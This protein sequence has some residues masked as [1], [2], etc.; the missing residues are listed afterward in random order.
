MQ[1]EK[2]QYDHTTEK[3]LDGVQY[4]RGISALLVVIS[5]CNGIIAKP[6]FYAAFV[7]PDLHPASVFAVAVFFAISGFII[8]V[9]S[10]DATAQAGWQPRMNAGEFARRRAIRILPF[11][12][13]CTLGYNLLSWAGT[14]TA[15]P[16][17]MLRTLAVWPVG[18]LKPN[19]VW[20]LRHELL[21][22]GLFA[23]TMMGARRKAWLLWLWV[24]ASGL[25]Y[26]L[27]YDLRPAMALAGG[28]WFEWLKVAMGGDH[29]ANL[30]FAAGMVLGL[31]YLRRRA[32]GGM[33][34]RLPPA[35]ML[36]LI[37]LGGWTV[38]TVIP[39]RTGVGPALAWT[40]LAAATLAAAVLARPAG[41]MAGRIGRVLGDA[42]FAIY[43]VHNPV[44]LALLALAKRTALP[45][46]TYPALVAFL[47]ASI[48]MTTL[49]GIAA[50]YWV[51]APLIRWCNRRLR[52]AR[53]TAPARQG[54]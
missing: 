24:G 30:Q 48:V 34:L 15:E 50:H 12:W 39:F 42:S 45:L 37:A 21:F 53:P 28:A 10:L 4:L 3:R 2:I 52:P 6:E 17:A 19:V 44:M 43:L 40:A 29:G 41:G 27:A 8:V 25:F 20:S 1:L 31:W 36:A 11:L 32:H 13:L 14:G 26:L 46:G 54:G 49:G 38:Q 7:V 5:H 18:E 33:M 23:A 47:V 35:L 22:Y 9:S 51:E 16:D